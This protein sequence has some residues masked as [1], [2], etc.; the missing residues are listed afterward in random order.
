LVTILSSCP[1]NRQQAI[2]AIG[3]Q[4]AG[5]EQLDLPP[6]PDA[7][8]YPTPDGY[9]R[10]YATTVS[11]TK[12][13]PSLVQ[14]GFLFGRLDGHVLMKTENANQGLVCHGETG[15][16][17]WPKNRSVV[18]CTQHGKRHSHSDTILSGARSKSP[19]GSITS[20]IFDSAGRVVGESTLRWS[21][22]RFP[23]PR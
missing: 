9:L 12:G 5:A 21:P 4:G 23:T 15:R 14:Y 19:S 1:R 2:L 16:K 7:A 18:T 10:F 22:F 8:A 11:R 3:V 6:K 17:D 13:G 20:P